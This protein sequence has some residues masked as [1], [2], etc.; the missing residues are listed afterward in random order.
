MSNYDKLQKE[1]KSNSFATQ[2]VLAELRGIALNP[3][4]RT[5][6][7]HAHSMQRS[8]IHSHKHREEFREESTSGSQPFSSEEPGPVTIPERQCKVY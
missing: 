4:L 8:A 2:K 5:G 1:E 3:P 6:E 7:P